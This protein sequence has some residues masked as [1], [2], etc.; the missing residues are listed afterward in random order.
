[1]HLYR[2]G[3][4]WDATLNIPCAA[5]LPEGAWSSACATRLYVKVLA[6]F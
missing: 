5:Y 2:V 1:M 4:M 3:P 6:E